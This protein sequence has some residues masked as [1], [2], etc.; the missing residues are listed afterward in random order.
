MRWKRLLSTGVLLCLLM[1]LLV[2][3]IISAQGVTV[4]I[5]S[6][7]E[8]DAGTAFIVRVNITDVTNFNVCNYNISYDPSVFKFTD[9]T[10]GLIGSTAIPVD[11]WNE[12]FS[13]TTNTTI[14]VEHL[15]GISGVNGSGYLA[16]LHFDVIGLYSITSEI[17]ISN[18]TLGDNNATK[19]Q[20]TWAN[21]SVNVI[22]LPMPTATLL[23][24]ATPTP[25]RAPTPTPSPTRTP[26]SEDGM[27]MAIW[28]W[29]VIGF[30]FV[31]LLVVI[32]MLIIRRRR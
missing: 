28:V 12:L 10:D 18:G 9:V 17:V 6:P 8:V 11:N 15:P 26:A 20:A 7:A 30:V 31:I 19:I 25:S 14:V 3:S 4:S 1:L 29:I 22:G 24:T 21:D 32:I 27:D 2:P 16:E 5:D 13:G 23:P